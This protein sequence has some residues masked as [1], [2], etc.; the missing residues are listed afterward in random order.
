MNKRG[1]NQ[2]I[3][4][5]LMIVLAITLGFLVFKWM[6]GTVKEGGQ[7]GGDRAIA[8]D[9]C[10]ED[11]KIRV[12]N[13]ERQGDFHIINVENLKQKLLSDFIIRYE[14]GEELE[15]KKARQVLGGYEN[16]N[17]KV[18]SPGFDPKVVKVIPQ[19]ILEKPELK[20]MDTGW[21][22]CSQQMAVFSL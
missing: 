21:W 11:V 18:P 4:V 8:Q 19:I 6:S 7:K 5:A 9:T 12:N 20:S 16:A 2:I 10:R 13:V 15:V 17:I 3:V 14:R 1:V 22:L